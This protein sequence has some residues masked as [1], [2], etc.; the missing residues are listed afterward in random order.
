VII[1]LLRIFYRVR[2]KNLTHYRK[3]FLVNKNIK[4]LKFALLNVGRLSRL[5]DLAHSSDSQEHLLLVDVGVTGR[6]LRDQT[7]VRRSYEARWPV[8]GGHSGVTVTGLI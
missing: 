5:Y 8:P 6:V 3:L 1:V 4:L 7:S 2:H